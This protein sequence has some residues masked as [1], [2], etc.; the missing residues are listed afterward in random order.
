[1][2]EP[3]LLMVLILPLVFSLFLLMRQH[4]ASADHA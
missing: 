3:G 1:M 4:I 2:F